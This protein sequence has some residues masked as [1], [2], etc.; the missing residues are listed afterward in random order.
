MSVDTFPVSDKFSASVDT[1]SVSVDTFPVSVDTFP[2]S[3][4]VDS[5]FESIT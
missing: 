1:L 5:D 4:S 2:V 3:F